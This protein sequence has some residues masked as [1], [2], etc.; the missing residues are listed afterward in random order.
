MEVEKLPQNERKLLLEGPIFPLNHD[1]GVEK[2]L[3][4]GRILRSG[5]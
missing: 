2:I 1:S 5:I 4:L 3:R